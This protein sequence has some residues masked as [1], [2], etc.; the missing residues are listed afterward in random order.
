MENN[1]SAWQQEGMIPGQP[2]HDPA[3]EQRRHK[4]LEIIHKLI[5]V[6][7]SPAEVKECAL[8]VNK[9]HPKPFADWD[10]IS[11]CNWAEKHYRSL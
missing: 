3:W 10:V 6:G 11:M 8:V 9:N 1:N 4:L 5:N 7:L 2:A